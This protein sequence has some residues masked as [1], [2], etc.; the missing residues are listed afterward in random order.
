MPC[1]IRASDLHSGCAQ[2]VAHDAN[3]V[4]QARHEVP[5]ARVDGSRAH[6]HQQV[7]IPDDRLVDVPELQHIG[8]TVLVLDECLHGFYP[9]VSTRVV[10]FRFL[11]V[12]DPIDTGGFGSL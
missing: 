3:Q 8:G 9:R 1:D 6:P 4:R 5:D 2:P 11:P 10:E 12:F 7:S